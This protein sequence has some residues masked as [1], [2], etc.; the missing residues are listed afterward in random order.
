MEMIDILNILFIAL[1]VICVILL[2]G[3]M[4]FL[5]RVNSK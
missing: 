4:L 3:L 2:F 5:P 1:G